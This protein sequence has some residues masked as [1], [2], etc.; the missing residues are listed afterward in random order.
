MTLRLLLAW[1]AIA[2]AWPAAAGPRIV[3][4]I[5]PVQ[6]LVAM[7][8][9]GVAV[10]EAILPANASP[11]GFALR[12]SQASALARADL[13]VWMGP[14]LT[15]WMDRAIANLAVDG[16][17]LT[18]LSLD[19]PGLLPRRAEAVFPGAGHDGHHEDEHHHGHARVHGGKDAHLGDNI[20]P[21]AWTDPDI[22]AAWLPEIA[23]HLAKRDPENEALYRENATTAAARLR[24]L[25]AETADRLAPVRGAEFIVLHDAYQYFERRMKLNVVGA[26]SNSDAAAPG[27]AR[28]RAVAGVAAA[29]RCIFT[30]PQTSPKAAMRLAKTHDLQVAVLDIM[31]AELS[32][33]PSLYEDLIRQMADQMAGCLGG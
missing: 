4:D 5:A 29:R 1:L 12:P 26:L 27:A 13:I 6:S 31:G 32:P 21:H 11:H 16:D 8:S 14:Q 28:L 20:D 15:P 17:V 33:G 23:D 18:L 30:E 3:T 9:D 24:A 7:V 22:A 10:P 25:A 2:V 19:V